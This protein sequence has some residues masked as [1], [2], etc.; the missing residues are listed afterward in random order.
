MFL[1]STPPGTR[2]KDT[3]ED[4]CVNGR[5]VA[6]TDSILEKR[7]LDDLFIAQHQK[8]EPRSHVHKGKKIIMSL[9]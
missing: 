1:S 7:G 4:K 6:R 8:L 5:E 3:R 9:K 2:E